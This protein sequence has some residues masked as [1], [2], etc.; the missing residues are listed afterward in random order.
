MAAKASGPW[1]GG[2]RY[3]TPD[4]LLE[5]LPLDGTINKEIVSSKSQS[6]LRYQPDH[7][8]YHYIRSSVTCVSP[9]VSPLKNCTT[10]GVAE[11]GIPVEW[12]T[13]I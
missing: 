12:H 9:G 5:P 11:E 7:L 4:W 1:W 10:A 13:H 6:L 2:M 8:W 3:D